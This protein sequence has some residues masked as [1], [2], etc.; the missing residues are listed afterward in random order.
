MDREHTIVAPATPTGEGGVGI[1]RLSGEAAEGLLKKIFRPT[2][3]IGSL[4][5][6]RL[7]HGFV[8]ESEGSV[9]DEVM[10]VLMRKPRSYTREDVAEIHC[11]GGPVVMR[12]ILDLLVEG[13]AR[14]ARPGEFTLR[15]FLNGRIDL[16][17]AEAVVELI[18]AR[19]EAASHVALGQME[20]RLSRAI[21]GF[22]ER[23]ADF[24]AEVE[25]HIDF[26]EEDIQPA[27]FD[28]LEKGARHLQDEMDRLLA[29]FESGRVL[30]EG[31]AVLILG[32][33]NVGKSS[34][35]N[36][37]LGEARAIVTDIPGT[38][39]DTLEENLVLHGL[40][41]RLVDTAG[42]RSTTDP[43]EAEGVRRARDKVASADL[44]LLVVDGSRQ[45]GD[46]DRLALQAC[47]DA[48]VLLVV[49]KG[50]LPQVPLPE[51][52]LDLPRVTVSVRSGEGIAKLEETVAGRFGG[53]GGTEGRET[54][55]LSDRR[56]REALLRASQCL[57]VFRAGLT[58]NSSPEFLALDLHETLDALGEITGETA[59]D[60]ILERIFTRFCIGK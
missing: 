7:Y 10:A 30:R 6:H 18:R 48:Q 23:T 19:S 39:R 53:D 14:I 52:F 11:H 33:P 28:R 51:A 37:L 32:R 27:G 5:S 13:G 24:L 45:V 26:P 2:A 43:V 9:V 1:V 36:V 59:P 41:L 21:H 56:H 3:D 57:G 25:A 35:M 46:E 31:L 40:P 58:G 47:R 42:V 44:V 54:T 29:T 34:L 17:Q 15:A 38:T 49:N 60:E 12:R 16:A 22:R 8:Q 20:G 50:D 55:L 4:E